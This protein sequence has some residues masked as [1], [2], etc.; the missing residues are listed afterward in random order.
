MVAATV[1]IPTFDHGPL[2][3]HSLASAQ[4]QSVRDIEIFVVGDG[5]PAL[6]RELVL[7]AAAKDPRI[8]YFDNPKGEGRGERHRHAALAAA[9]GEIACYLADDDLWF[10]DHVA[11]MRD[12]LAEADFASTLHGRLGADGTIEAEMVDL[13]LSYYRDV[14]MRIE[15]R[16]PTSFG[17]HSM[18]IYRRLPQG[19]SVGPKGLPTDLHMWRR[20]LGLSGCRAKSAPVPTGLCFPS[21]PRRHMTLG[22]REA[23]L[24]HWREAIRDPAQLAAIKVEIQSQALRMAAREA[25]QLSTLKDRLIGRWRRHLLRTKIR[26]ARVPHL[27]ASWRR[28]C[29][30]PPLP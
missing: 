21:P 29:G 24:A 1:L 25:Q 27:R 13:A 2:V 17:A 11:T 5:A 22:E 7:A 12:L 18:A 23:E 9:R 14:I 30:K 26:L 28:L 16:I 19:W 15:N 20:I 3:A 4:D 8:R 10:P 6:T